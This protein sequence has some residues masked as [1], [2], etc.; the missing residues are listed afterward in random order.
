MTDNNKV[1]TGLDIGTTKVKA[2]VGMPNPNGKI[3]LLAVAEAQSE[4]VVRSSITNIDKTVHAIKQVIDK[5]AQEA[6]VQITSAN[7]SIAGR[8]T[9]STIHRSGIT[10]DS[11]ESEITKADVDRLNTDM[12]RINTLPGHDILDIVPKEYTVDYEEGIKDPVGMSGIRLEGMFHVITAQT[13]VIN[14]LYKCTR[15]AGLKIDNLILSPLASSLSV[16]TEEEKEAGVCLV[17]IGASM[18]GITIYHGGS[19]KHT[20]LIPFGGEAITKDLAQAFMLMEPQAE[21]LKI[22]YGS[23]YEE[24]I[25][26]EIVAIPGLRNRPEKEIFLPVI[27]RM[28]EARVE[29]TI[30]LVYREIVTTGFQ[31]KLPGGIVITGGGA[32]LRKVHKLFSYI[33]GYDTRIGYPYESLR[34]DESTFPDIEFATCI[35]L[36]LANYKSLGIPE[37]YYRSKEAIAEEKPRKKAKKRGLW[38]TF[39]NI[40]K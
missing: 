33:T 19:L 23:A 28:I 15:R 36:V 1:F 31:D 22:K 7:V 20:S 30:Q 13:N 25:K 26:N 3:T 29:E 40:F 21:E 18:M 16:L 6:N 17:D 5:T 10:R 9:K 4:G 34:G 37:K 32:K 12:Y 8:H 11:A 35:G 14:N 2:I 24:S 27:D 39:K 38:H